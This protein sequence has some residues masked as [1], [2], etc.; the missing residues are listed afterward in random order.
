[1]PSWSRSALWEPNMPG[2]RHECTPLTAVPNQGVGSVWVFIFV[3]SV[4]SCVQ[5]L[6]QW[7]TIS[8]IIWVFQPAPTQ[9]YF[10]QGL[11]SLPERDLPF[12]LLFPVNL[13]SRSVVL[14]LKCWSVDHFTGSK[15]RKLRTKGKF[16]TKLN[17]STFKDYPLPESSSSS[18]GFNLKGWAVL[19]RNWGSLSVFLDCLFIT[20]L[21]FSFI[22]LQKH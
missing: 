1:M 3:S 7:L 8:Q 16:I 17:V 18:Q 15:R 4:I 9:F 11:V 13:P 12:S 6:A 19:A 5:V 22:L 2:V 21:W 14:V 20:N 10:Y